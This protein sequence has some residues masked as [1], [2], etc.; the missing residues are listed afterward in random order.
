MPNCRIQLQFITLLPN[1]KPNIHLENKNK[2]AIQVF[3]VMYRPKYWLT[4]R[5]HF[6]RNQK[7]KELH[8][9]PECHFFQILGLK[10]LK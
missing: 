2:H 4:D 3:C 1:K 6:K 5:F 7:K 10:I 8:L 9:N